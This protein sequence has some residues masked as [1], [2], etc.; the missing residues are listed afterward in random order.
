MPA[1]DPDFYGAIFVKG[2]PQGSYRFSCPSVSLFDLVARFSTSAIGY[3]RVSSTDQNVAV[4]EDALRPA[5]C[6]V[7]S[8]QRRE[9]ARPS[10]GATSLR[11]FSISSM[12]AMC[13]EHIPH[14]RMRIANGRQYVTCNASILPA[15]VRDI[16]RSDA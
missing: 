5:G 16:G 4:K 13:W 3:A 14:V 9:A 7:P 15:K 6:S 10:R 11:P 2:C 1:L 12:P 8:A